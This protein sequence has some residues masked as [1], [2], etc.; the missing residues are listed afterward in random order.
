MEADNQREHKEKEIISVAFGSAASRLMVPEHP[1]PSRGGIEAGLRGARNRGP[2]CY[3]PSPEELF[4]KEL[5]SR[6]QSTRG[7]MF[8]ATT[9]KRFPQA[10]KEK[11][12]GP[13]TYQPNVRTQITLSYKPFGS[14]TSRRPGTVDKAEESPGPGH[15]EHDVVKNRHVEVMGSFGGNAQIKEAVFTKCTNG[16]TDKC[17]QCNCSMVGD[18]WE[19]NETTLCQACYDKHLQASTSA[20]KNLNTWQKVRDCSSIHKHEGT[21]AQIQLKSAKEQKKL[22]YREA[23]LK[24]YYS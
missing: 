16:N 11:M 5:D 23:Y 9:A 3:G 20:Y 6:P 19:K 14:A 18:Y 12:P 4:L 22:K 7:V 8:G 21:G 1:P 13:A 15:Y 10:R 24:L 2:G 17:Q